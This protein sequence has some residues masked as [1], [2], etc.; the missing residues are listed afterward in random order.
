[1]EN[2]TG[3]GISRRNLLASIAVAAGLGTAAGVG[4]SL[5]WA[6]NSLSF[7]GYLAQQRRKGLAE[8]AKTVFPSTGVETP[9]TFGDSIQKLVEAGVISPA[10]FEQIYASRGGLPDWVTRL[11]DNPSDKPITLSLSNAPYLLNL[12]WPLGLANKTGFNETSPL[13]G[14]DG[15]N[16]AS[17]GGWVLGQARRGGGYFNSVDAIKLSPEQEATVLAAAEKS[18][19]PCCN[20]S[21]FFQDCN[22]GSALLGLYQLAA[23]QGATEAQLYRIGLTANSFW[24]P[25]KYFETAIYYDQLLDTRWKDAPAEQ[26][27]SAELSSLSGWDKNIHQSLSRQG[28]IP[29]LGDGGGSAGCSA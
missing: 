15:G 16:F 12:L 7:Q 17:T 25:E 5:W 13:A 23:A 14:K 29:S 8:L 22:H 21:T 2:K 26:I 10:K 18:Y 20:N 9:F 24:Y 1:M 11:M 27:I 6:S 4:G 19:R 3:D 28:I